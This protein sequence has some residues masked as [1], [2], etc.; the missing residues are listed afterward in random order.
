MIEKIDE[1]TKKQ[2]ESILKLTDEKILANAL[3]QYLNSNKKG[4]NNGN[5][6][7]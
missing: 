4:N 7:K 1:K 2:L 6:K 3:K 5:K